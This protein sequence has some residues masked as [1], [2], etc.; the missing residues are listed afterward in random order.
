MTWSDL[1]SWFAD[2]NDI[3]Q[4]ILQH[5]KL[6]FLPVAAAML[7]ALPVG[8]YIGHKRRLE[9]AAVS[10]ANLGRAIPSF[11]ILALSFPIAIKIG[12]WVDRPELGLGFWPT[13]VALFFLSIPPIM[14]NAYIGVKGVDPDAVESGRGQGLSEKQILGRVEVPLAMPL[15][16]AGVRTAAVQ[17]VATATLGALVAGG[18]LGT[19]ILLGFRT[20]DRPS[21]VGGGILVAL[22]AIATELTF[23][24]VS[25]ALSPK[26]VSKDLGGFELLGQVPHPTDVG[27]GV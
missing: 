11:G 14:T 25:R 19:Y 10:I 22:V 12:S 16:I 3:P 27:L 18:G 6:S 5:L 20:G 13:F 9:F 24:L 17:A 7:I 15:I 2:T 21:L 23:S 1:T 26:M 8:L 4:Q